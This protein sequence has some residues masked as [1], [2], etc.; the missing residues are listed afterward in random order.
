MA[1]HSPDLIP[2]NFRF[3]DYLKGK[4]YRGNV[5]NLADLKNQMLVQTCN[6]GSG[7][8]HA[9]V[10]HVI[11]PCYMLALKQGEHIKNQK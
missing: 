4:V 7:Q 5:R 9:V 10:D 11:T 1:S 3:W 6:T 8:L 2:W